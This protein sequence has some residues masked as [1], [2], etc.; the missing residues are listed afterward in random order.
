MNVLLLEFDLFKSVGGGQTVYRRLIETNPRIT[1][2]YFGVKE[3]ASTVRPAN[4]KL[5]PFKITY[6][7]RNPSG[8]F[9]G[10]DQPIWAQ[11][12]YA[13]AAN[14][15]AAAAHLPIDVVDVPDYKFFGYMMGPALR[16]HGLDRCKVVLAMHGNL[17]ET[18]RVNWGSQDLLEICVD[19]R[20]QWQYRTADIR[21]GISRD[22]LEHWQAI[23]GQAGHYLNPLRFVLPPKPVKWNRADTALSLNFIGRTEGFKGPD[24]F[25]EL[26]TWLPTG[27]YQ[28][29]RLIGPGVID[30]QG[31]HSSVHLQRM[32]ARRGLPVQL[33]DCMTKGE[34][35]E[36]YAGRG[37][38]VLPSRMDTFNLTALESLYAG[39]P[40]AVSEH[41]GV[42]RF[43][44]E[45]YPEV[46]FT[47]L[48][49]V[50]LDTS[51]SALKIL[52]QGYDRHR[53]DLAQA[54]EKA[55]P[56]IIGPDLAQI[57]EQ[58]GSG[59]NFLGKQAQQLYDR[60]EIFNRK[61]RTPAHHRIVTMG[62][63]ANEVLRNLQ[64]GVKSPGQL[65]EPGTWFHQRQ[66]YYLPEGTPQEI[67]RKVGMAAEITRSSRLDRART[68]AELARLERVRGN[69]FVAATYEIR[70][71][72]ALGEDRFGMLP[73]VRSIL[74]ENGFSHEEQTV[75][76]LYGPAD[77]RLARGRTLLAVARDGHRQIPDRPFEFVEDG[78][79]ERQP[80]VSIIVS[81][82]KAANKLAAFLRMLSQHEWVMNGLAELVFVDS[83]S[84]TDEHAMF[85]QVGG[86][87]GVRAVYV[88]TTERETIQKAWN[89]GILLARA[90]YLSFLGVDEMVRPDCLSILAGEL[91]VDASLDWVQGNSVITE[92][93]PQG[94]LLRDVMIYQRIP[95]EQDLVYLETCYLSWVGG[96]Y[97]KSIHE[98][99]GYYDES[100]G[101]AGDTEFKN[102]VL[103]FIRSKTLPQ[104]LGV[105]LNYP[106]ER[107]TAS[108][109]AEVEDLRAWYLHRSEAGVE[110]ALARRPAEDAITLLS[111]A[112]GYR[113]SYC[114]HI[115]TDIEYALA[116]ATVAAGR[117]PGRKLDQ[118]ANALAQTLQGYRELDWLTTAT[119]RSGVRAQKRVQHLAQSAAQSVESWLN[120]PGQL[121]WAIVNDNRFEQHAY[122]W[123]AKGLTEKFVPGERALWMQT[124]EAVAVVCVSGGA[125]EAARSKEEVPAATDPQR[126]V[127]V[128]RQQAEQFR[129]VGKIELVRDLGVLAQFFHDQIEGKETP[130]SNAVG[131]GPALCRLLLDGTQ[132]RS[133]GN[134]T[135]FDRNFAGLC[136]ILAELITPL[137][138]EL[139][140]A[141]DG[142]GSLAAHNLERTKA[143]ELAAR[144]LT[145]LAPAEAVKRHSA[146][147]DRKVLDTVQ[148]A[149]HTA[150]ASGNAAYAGRLVTLATAINGELTARESRSPLTAVA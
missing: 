145:Y 46:P 16:R 124:K 33:H 103:P 86:A 66:L 73:W 99:C 52:M 19:Q 26:L 35:A 45:T 57:Y 21:Y 128:L 93:N 100:F 143:M 34:M 83:H 136:T 38:T 15:A 101:A 97:R 94:T 6:P 125:G 54:L 139:G 147:L 104:T 68:W 8:E 9:P 37:I 141:L 116:V 72:R 58:G 59:E 132:G 64:D 12:D 130:I 53:E 87:L 29:A 129:K 27:S 78:R 84:P 123:E 7:V 121:S 2:Y 75:V 63:K 5:I 76:A 18:Q 137:A 144:L 56:E 11:M 36:I 110:Y 67:D 3:E 13:S 30:A 28:M 62:V 77:E 107:T 47:T 135:L 48:R 115:S 60:A 69:D 14:F 111:K 22:Y 44:R 90:P 95:Y 40:V 17:S 89:R 39:C 102:R 55:R 1:F 142:L 150:Q 61:F 70:V 71:M 92:V 85:K 80:K 113:K 25:L 23:G 81:L 119:P 79:L 98:R 120:L 50:Q 96:M 109:R 131:A 148:R 10:L 149:A 32:A 118:V 117:L 134:L 51:A 108:P 126:L 122:P 31:V 65:P 133:P 140:D 43:L 42:C 91:D 112:V 146:E 20:E 105:F 127:T 74:L 41:A 4:A 106:E 49:V 138:G 114:G 24:L 88:R 82:Y